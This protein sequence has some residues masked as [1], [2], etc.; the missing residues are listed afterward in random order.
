M[1]KIRCGDRIGVDLNQVAAWRKVKFKQSGT[2]QEFIVLFFAG[3]DDG[4]CVYEESVGCQAF[5][6]LH[7][8]LL[9][10]FAID[11][12]ADNNLPS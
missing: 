5:A 8:L 6:Y 2:E 7:K 4:L 9:D 11:L 12:A 1:T 10:R 3:G